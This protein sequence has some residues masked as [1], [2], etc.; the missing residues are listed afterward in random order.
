MRQVEENG[1]KPVAVLITHGH[2]DHTGGV[3][4][5]IKEYACPL[6]FHEKDARIIGRKPD[7]EIEEGDEG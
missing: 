5:L 4:A 2:P 7:R 1:Y 6:I 3:P